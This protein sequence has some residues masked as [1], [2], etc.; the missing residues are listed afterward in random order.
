MDSEGEIMDE[1]LIPR[2]NVVVTISNT[3]YIKR[4][5]VDTYRTQR[6]GGMGVMGMETKEEDYV[7]D[8]FVVIYP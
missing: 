1:D 8:I 4:Q 2:E 7:V 6:R 5:P 3:G